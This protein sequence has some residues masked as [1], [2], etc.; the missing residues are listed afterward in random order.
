M[1]LFWSTEALLKHLVDMSRESFN[2]LARPVCLVYLSI[3]KEHEL[4]Y[5]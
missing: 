1:T 2:S 3:Q 5:Y 4:L